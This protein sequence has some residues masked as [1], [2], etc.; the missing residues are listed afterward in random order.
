MRIA[1][2]SEGED[3]SHKEIFDEPT[4]KPL[5]TLWR[6]T[7]RKTRATQSNRRNTPAANTARSTSEYPVT[8]RPILDDI[9]RLLKR[10]NAPFFRIFHAP[11]R[12]PVCEFG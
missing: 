8:A 11:R 5:F 1:S 12:E 6:F 7:I 10:H 4:K 3:S 2:P 9:M